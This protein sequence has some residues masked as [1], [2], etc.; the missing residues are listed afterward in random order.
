MEKIAER[1]SQEKSGRDAQGRPG[2]YTPPSPI[3]EIRRQLGWGLI[4]AAHESTIKRGSR[5]A[6]SLLLETGSNA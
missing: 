6:M 2:T 4:R 1:S 5:A 3:R